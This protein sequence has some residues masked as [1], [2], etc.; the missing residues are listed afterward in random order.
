MRRVTV[1]RCVF[2]GNLANDDGGGIYARRAGVQ[3]Y[4]SLINSNLV[5]GSG[6]A[7]GS[8]GDI[9]VVRSRVDGNTT[10]GDGGA[11]YA[12]EDG[13]ITV[14]DSTVNGSTAD[15]PG[16]AIFTLDGDVTVVNS[17]LTATAPTIAVARSPARPTSRLEL[18]HRPQ[19]RRRARRWGDLGTRRRLDHQLH[20]HRQLRR[21]PGRR[22]SGRRQPGPHLFDPH[23]QLR[24]PSRR[25]RHRRAPPRLR[26]GHRPAGYD[27]RGWPRPAHL[28]DLRGPR[29]LAFL[30]LQLH[31]RHSCFTA[32][33]TEPTD[34]VG[35]ADPALGPLSPNPESGRPCVPH[36]AARCSTRSRGA[37]AIRPVRP[38]TSRASSTS[39]SSAS[40]RS[41]P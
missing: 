15:G 5:D 36:R 13:D 6:G 40:T 23:R 27:L 7:I 26:L 30:R 41:P 19:P 18:D 1:Y 12:D 28:A 8:T 34:I 10:D 4:D 3:V 16:G 25:R 11:L 20:G 31:H 22:R 33:N 29:P 17:T 21:G 37:P 2:T 14:I 9:L 39:V 38:R 35:V 24:L 32:A